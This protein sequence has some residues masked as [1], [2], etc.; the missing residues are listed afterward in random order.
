M[1]DVLFNLRLLVLANARDMHEAI[2]LNMMQGMTKEVKSYRFTTPET[3][4]L[5]DDLVRNPNIDNADRNYFILRMA[6]YFKKRFHSPLYGTVT[7]LTNNLLGFDITKNVVTR[8]VRD[9]G[10]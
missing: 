7:T 8:V 10:I 6:K 2:G 5:D 3:E 1:T 9:S 4:L